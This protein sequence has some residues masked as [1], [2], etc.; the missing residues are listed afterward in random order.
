[1][2]IVELLKKLH[3]KPNNIKIYEQAF[4][5]SSYVNER[6]MIN[7]YERLEFLGDAVLDVVI[8]DYLYTHTKYEEGKMTKLRSTYVCENAI[9][10]YA[11]RLG[12]SKYIK[13]GR[14]EELSGGRY[15]K[16]IL[17]DTFE[18]FVGAIYIDQGFAKAKE[19]IY[20]VV[21]PY[22]KAG[23]I[24]FLNDHK[25]I[26]QELVQT[27]QKSVIY[28]LIKEEGPPHNKTFTTIVK[29]NNIVFGTGKAGSKKEA[30]QKAAENALSK[31]ANKKNST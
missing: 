15:R 6:R 9:A 14:G 11:E 21:V 26:F 8:S 23:K 20:Q 12:F 17:A 31:L 10:K 1:M 19:F 5:H 25:S 2:I 28:E 16:A 4:F 24:D 13:V 27:H 3:I 7:N 22:L 18:A 29:V 30:E